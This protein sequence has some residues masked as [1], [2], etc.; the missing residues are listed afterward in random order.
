M[1]PEVGKLPREAIGF[2]ETAEKAK[3]MAVKDAAE[4]VRAL[5]AMQKPP[6]DSFVVSEDYARQLVDTGKLGDDVKNEAFEKPLKQWVMP[7][8]SDTDWW[9]DVVR[10][11]FDAQRS[12]RAADR[13]TWSSRGMLGLAALL[14]A[15]V[16]YVRL[17]EYTHRRYTTWL[18]IAGIGVAT[19]AIA[20]IAYVFQ[21]G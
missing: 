20:G 7:F 19:S 17:D 8:R 5:M 10:H 13:Q 2:G 15:A 16:G 1:E 12:A 4:R 6:L 21:A 9:G 18:R 11:D 14:L 3:A